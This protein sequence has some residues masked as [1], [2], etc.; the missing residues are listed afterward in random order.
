MAPEGPDYMKIFYN[1]TMRKPTTA[2]KSE[3]KI[4]IDTST[5]K[6]PGGPVLTWEDS[7]Y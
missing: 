1:S 2:L 3:N 6:L 5:E 4:W 7:Q